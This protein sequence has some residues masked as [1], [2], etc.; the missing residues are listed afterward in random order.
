MSF[1]QYS[2][3]YIDTSQIQTVD[4][5]PITNSI[6]YQC[7]FLPHSTLWGCGIIA[8]NFTDNMPS[9]VCKNAKTHIANGVLHKL[10]PGKYTVS[11]ILNE[12][13]IDSNHIISQTTVTVIGTSCRIMSPS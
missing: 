7:H 11:L 2:I 13:S 6:R 10:C 12:T 5:T 1:S 9:F 8:T 3:Y 4:I